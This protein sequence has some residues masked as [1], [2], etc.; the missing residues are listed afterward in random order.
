VLV[1]A[2]QLGSAALADEAHHLALGLHHDV[3]LL[4]RVG[5]W[6]TAGT[7]QRMVMWCPIDMCFM[8]GLVGWEWEGVKRSSHKEVCT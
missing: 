1:V 3:H 5:V 6:H 4:D 8:R 2:L 7:G